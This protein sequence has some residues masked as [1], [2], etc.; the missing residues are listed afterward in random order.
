MF[1]FFQV[2]SVEI[3]LASALRREKVADT[4]IKQL[5]AEIEQ[6]NRLVEMDN[7][8]VYYLVVVTDY[9]KRFERVTM[10]SNYRFARERMIHKAQK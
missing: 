10:L 1:I 4:T 5:Q 7:C 3:V 2:K 8:L 9:R 6:L